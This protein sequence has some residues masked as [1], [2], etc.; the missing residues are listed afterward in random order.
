M[1]V[2]RKNK[3]E[4]G[5]GP[6]HLWPGLCACGGGAIGVTAVT[7]LGIRP[8]SESVRGRVIYGPDCDTSRSGAV[9]VAAATSLGIRSCMRPSSWGGGRLCAVTQK[10]PLVGSGWQRNRLQS[11]NEM[12][13]H[14]LNSSFTSSPH[15]VVGV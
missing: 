14:H 2:K 10:D 5:V 6:G 11:A 3:E 7:S 9:G 15:S 1:T 4:L 12:G 13:P 8:C